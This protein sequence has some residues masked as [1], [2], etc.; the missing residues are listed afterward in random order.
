MTPVS[1]VLARH[2]AADHAVD[3]L[4]PLARGVRL[5]LQPHVAVLAAA[6]GLAHELAFALDRAADGLAVGDLRL[7]DVGLDLELALHAVDDD[8]EV[9][10]AHARDDRLPRLLVG[11]DAERGV[12]LGEALQSQA[13]LLLVGLGL[14]LHRHRDDGSREFHLLQ[15]DP[16]H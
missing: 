16:R 12:F 14:R 4:V 2:R 3:E 15:R 13:H 5:D 1:H 6:A 9:Q 8:L 11:A 10:L 7:A